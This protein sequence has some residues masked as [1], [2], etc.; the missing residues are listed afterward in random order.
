[1]RHNH[2]RD[3]NAELQREV[4]RDVVLEPALIPPDNEQILGT[5]TD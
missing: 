1:M 2:I 4:C 5:Y 3:L